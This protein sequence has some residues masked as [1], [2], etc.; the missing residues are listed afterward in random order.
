MKRTLSKL[1]V[2]GVVVLTS[3]LLSATTMKKMSI[4]E[5]VQ[6]AS[7]CVVAK[8][9]N[10]KQVYENGAMVT[11]TTFEVTDTAFGNTPQLITVRTDGG[12][13]QLTKISTTEVVAGT[14]QF[15]TNDTSMLFLNENSASSDYSV[16]GVSQGMFPVV[17][18]A[19]NLPE[20]EGKTMK[21]KE[22]I[23]LMS[24]RKNSGKK[25]GLPQ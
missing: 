12:S 10:A 9:K 22:A 19:V 2:A 6:T 16:V 8:A 23:K 13:R 15:F 1:F 17:D 21:V 18:S 7:A 11:L 24:T 3:T 20:N 5:I 25:L 4:E 14:P